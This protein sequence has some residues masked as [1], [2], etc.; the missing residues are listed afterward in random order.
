MSVKVSRYLYVM[1]LFSSNQILLNFIT[2]RS[3]TRLDLL[4][5]KSLLRTQYILPFIKGFIGKLI[6]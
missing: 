3:N 4:S 1:S 5:L 6:P 2:S